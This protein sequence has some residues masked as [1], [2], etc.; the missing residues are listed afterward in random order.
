[1][2]LSQTG[3]TAHLYWRE[4]PNH[5]AFVILDDFIVM[6]NHIHGTIII[7]KPRVE[8]QDVASLP[9]N[10]FGPQSQNLSSI[11][12]GYKS[13]VKKYAVINNFEFVWQ[14]RFYDH[15]IRNEKSFY[16]I[17]EYIINNPAKWI[18][19]NYYKDEQ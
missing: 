6:P 16:K 14:S 15:I 8:T 5:F 12:R 9:K 10:K 13:A 11:I 4:I 3:K 1:M 2:Q 19:D 7:D 18:E 17:K